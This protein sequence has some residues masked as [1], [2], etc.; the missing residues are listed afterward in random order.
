MPG[1]SPEVS[2]AYH[3]HL[4]T[5]S[6]MNDPSNYSPGKIM[7]NQ[8]Y[9]VVN[10]TQK[11]RECLALDGFYFASRSFLSDYDSSYRLGYKVFWRVYISTHIGSRYH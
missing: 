7:S 8:N 3:N 4:Y 11:K 10:L 5:I 1:D 6:A 9:A 2:K